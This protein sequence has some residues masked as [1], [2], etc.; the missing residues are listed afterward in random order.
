MTTISRKA[1][2]PGAVAGR[3]V[4]VNS[5]EVSSSIGI[6]EIMGRRLFGGILPL[7]NQAGS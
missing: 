2:D 6:I 1:F 3:K 5:G 4:Q 7:N